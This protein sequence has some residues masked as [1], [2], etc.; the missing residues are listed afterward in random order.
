MS[1]LEAENE[2]L[3]KELKKQ[4]RVASRSLAIYQQRA[5]QME[6]IRQQNED[7]DRLAADLAKAKRLAEDRAREVEEAARLKSEFLANFSH[8]IRTPLNGIIGYC[9]LLAQEEG[10]R[11]SPHGRRDLTTIRKNAKTLLALINDI[12]DLS[13]IESG[14]VEVVKEQVDVPSL[15]GDCKATVG[16][17]LRGKEVELRVRV[18]EEARRVFTDGLKL[19]QIVLNLLSNAAKFTELGE[20]SVTARADGKTLELEV[21]DTGVGIPPEQV[22]K[23]FEKFR[24]VDGSFTRTKGG[25]GLGL[26]I[27]RELSQLLGGSVDVSSTVGRGTRFV[28]RLPDVVEAGASAAAPERD[29]HSSDPTA[30]LTIA[31]DTRVLLVDDDP[32]IQQLVGAKLREEGLTVEVAADG[33]EALSMLRAD[34]PSVVVL[35]LRLPKLDGWSVL[36]TV[37]SD[38]RLCRIPVVILSVEEERGRGFALGAFDYLVKPVDPE[39]LSS[40]VSSAVSPASGEILVVDDDA[41]TRELVRRRMQKEGFDVAEATGG[42]DALLRIRFS[43]PALMVLDLMMPEVDGFEVLERVR[44]AGHE[45]PVVVLTGKE[46]TDADTTRLREAFARV[47]RKNGVSLDQV[48][49]ET[50]RHVTR[51]RTVES[52][53]LPRVLYVEDVAQNRDIVRRYLHGVVELAEA[54]DGEHGLELAQRDRPDLVLMDLSLPRVDGWTATKT[55]KEREETASIPVVALTAHASAEDRERALDAGCCDYLT[56]PV[57]RNQLIRTIRKNL[58]QRA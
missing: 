44:S 39:R 40:V 10:E 34:P 7:L 17:M 57:E 50:K 2:R 20:I 3:K 46:L 32:M 36:A 58:K 15:L 5:L 1:D 12:L 27:V 28:V 51:R 47:I 21:D 24:Q 55:L 6:L 18:E 23:I 38:E 4:K 30:G 54:H 19:R 8:E 14:Q 26:A 13:K 48:V 45:F 53:R 11:L 29:R 25:T 52:A 37:K 49:E 41:D 56:K 43:P 31:G 35:D 33:T 16:E 9:D 42:E 22:K